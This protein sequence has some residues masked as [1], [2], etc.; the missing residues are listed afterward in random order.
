ME[1]KH[2]K[3]YAKGSA[4]EIGKNGAIMIT[5]KLDQL[6]EYMDSKNYVRLVIL[7]KWEPDQYG[8]THYLTIDRPLRQSSN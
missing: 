4:K 8:N 6:K 5:L 2:S 3:V 7:K 1:E